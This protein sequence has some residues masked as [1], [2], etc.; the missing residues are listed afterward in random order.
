M[1]IKN[2]AVFDALRDAAIGF[3]SIE[4]TRHL[5]EQNIQQ[6]EAAK[7]HAL[8]VIER[9]LPEDHIAELVEAGAIEY[10][11]A[12]LTLKYLNDGLA[13]FIDIQ[14]PAGLN[15]LNLKPAKDNDQEEQAHG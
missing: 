7:G 8:E 3:S 2:Q 11:D 4:L 13:L 12:R 5:L 15:L 1:T 9:E 6:A 10:G 14:P